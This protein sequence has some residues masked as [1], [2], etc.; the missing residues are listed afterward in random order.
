MSKLP[1]SEPVDQREIIEMPAQ[2]HKFIKFI[3]HPTNANILYALEQ[4]EMPQDLD[5]YKL[6]S[7]EEVYGQRKEMTK[8]RENDK[9]V[10]QELAR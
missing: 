3:F 9:I 4:D 8:S 7:L 2:R 5:S 6:V 10:K 1:A